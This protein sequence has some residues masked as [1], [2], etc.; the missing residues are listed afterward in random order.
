MQLTT[1]ELRDV[2]LLLLKVMED[3]GY[4]RVS[5]SEEDSYYQRIGYEE[6]NFGE[7]PPIAIGSLDDDMGR[8]KRALNGGYP[9]LA[10]LN[11]LGA[12]FSALGAVLTRDR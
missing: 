5:F 12:V 10:D 2:T 11:R 7:T 9:I 3:H 1:K 4:S 6:R 8:L